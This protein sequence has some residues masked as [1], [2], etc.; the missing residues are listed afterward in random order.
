MYNILKCVENDLKSVD[1]MLRKEYFIKA[2]DLNAFARVEQNY[3]ESTICPGAVILTGRLFNC[4]NNK[5][6]SLAAVIQFIYIASKI[7]GC[8]S[9]EDDK[10][11]NVE[12]DKR[13]GSQFPVLVGDFL[14]GKYFTF[15]CNNNMVNY[16][17]PLSEVICS[18]HEAGTIKEKTPAVET[19]SIMIDIIIKEFAVLFETGCR[20]AADISGVDSKQQEIMLGFGKN[21]GIA[22]GLWQK[23]THLYKIN[24]HLRKSKDFLELIPN[25]IYKDQLKH[26]LQFFKQENYQLN[27][28]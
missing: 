24:T 5:I 6:I 10:Y 26:L 27:C 21:F 13:D 15:L 12:K 22:Y 20:L 2:G 11:S 28:C 19:D 1:E 14:Y 18:I 3:L 16:L 9:E 7:H 25:N 4:I 8:V 17:K 23:N